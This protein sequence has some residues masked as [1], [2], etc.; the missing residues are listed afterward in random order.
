MHQSTCQNICGSLI[1]RRCLNVPERT[2]A[3]SIQMQTVKIQIIGINLQLTAWSTLISYTLQHSSLAWQICTY[4]LQGLITLWS[5]L[6]DAISVGFT[7]C[8]GKETNK[9]GH[10]FCRFLE[11]TS[12]SVTLYV[13]AKCKTHSTKQLTNYLCNYSKVSSLVRETFLL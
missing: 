1:S 9:T 12:K 2:L 6:P 3:S 7:S 8:P 10:S 11:S 13:H 4:P 5:G